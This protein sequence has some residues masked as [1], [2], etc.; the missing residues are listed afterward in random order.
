L[1]GRE[2]DLFDGQQA[3]VVKDVAVNQCEF[4]ALYSSEK[5]GTR[6]R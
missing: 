2:A 3:I 5:N 1:S 4:L 6:E